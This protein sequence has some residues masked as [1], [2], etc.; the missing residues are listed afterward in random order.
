MFVNIIIKF[1]W[2][3]YMSKK[4]TV[5]NIMKHKRLIIISLLAAGIILMILLVYILT[6]VNNKPKPFASDSNVKITN[7]CDYFDFT[8][9]AV[10]I[11]LKESSKGANDAQIKYRGTITNVKEKVSNV[12]LSVEIHTNWTTKTDNTGSEA[13]FTTTTL[14]NSTSTYHTSDTT[15]KLGNGYPVKVMPLVRVKKP[16]IYAKV[17]FDVA[18]PASMHGESG[19]ETLT[20]YYKIP[21]SQ[22]YVDGFTTLM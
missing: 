21:Y 6:Y 12:K 20:V 7:K 16:T 13:S 17:T 4:D 1:I 10:T 8:V 9:E 15:I 3:S 22:Y 18:T 14:N 2:V 5:N 19:T 11:Q